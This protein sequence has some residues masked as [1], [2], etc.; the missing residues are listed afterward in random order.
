MPTVSVPE[1]RKRG[2]IASLGRAPPGA[3]DTQN[4]VSG[5]RVPTFDTVLR[6]VGALG[7]TPRAEA[8]AAVQRQS[9]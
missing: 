5:E 9:R 2:S 8:S 7:L 4:P 3:P 1:I 6:V